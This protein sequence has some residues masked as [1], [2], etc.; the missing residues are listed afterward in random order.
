[1]EPERSSTV[2]NHDGLT[3]KERG[4]QFTQGRGCV[5]KSLVDARRARE[6]DPNPDLQ[7]ETSQDGRARGS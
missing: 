2:C 5:R 3:R 6:G 7:G 1:M 4:T